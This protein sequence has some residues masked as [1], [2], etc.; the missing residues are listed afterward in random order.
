ML[1]AY[2]EEQHVK[3]NVVRR[4]LPLALLV[5][6]CAAAVVVAVS[7]A[8]SPMGGLQFTQAGHWVANSGLGL[9][10]HVNG[11]AGGVDARAEVPGIEPGS[12]VVQ[13]ETSG[14]V[15]GRSRVTEFGKSTLSVQRSLT[16][17]TGEEPIAVETAGGPYLVYREAGSV[18]RLGDP[19]A[20][21][22][23]G[24]RLGDP[25]GTPDGT[26][27][28]HRVDSG[29]L[30]RLAKDAG[31]ISCPITL[32]AGHTGALTTVGGRAVFV[33][34][35][36]DVLR[37]ISGD[38][39]GEPVPIGTDV[40]ANARVAPADA[41]GRIAILDQGGRRV[42]FVATDGLAGRGSTTPLGTV[43]LPDGDY[44]GPTASGSSVVLLD[45]T[46]NTVL[47]YD[48]HGKPQERTTIPHENGQP[49]LTRA[50]DKRV[51]VDGAEGRHV[52][53]VDHDGKVTQVPVVGTEGVDKSTT[54]QA[55][56]AVPPP[57]GSPPGT[58]TAPPNTQ[59]G[60]PPQRTTTP[61]PRRTTQ[62]PAPSSRTAQ[63][64][65][66]VPASPPGIPPGV[67]AAVQ[68]GNIRVTWGTAAN[69]G[70]PVTAYQVSW[71]PGGGGASQPAGVRSMLITGLRQGVVYT[72]TVVAQN[73]AGRGAPGT[74]QAMIPVAQTRTVTVSRGKTERHDDNCDVP[75]CGYM[76]I[77]MRG[78]EPRKRYH[79]QPYSNG[80]YDNPGV[81]LSTDANGDL[82]FERFLFGQV[83]KQVWVVV[84]GK[85]SNHFTWVSG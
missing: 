77:E 8:A 19:A 75:E 82:T 13:G 24:G 43:V 54:S 67:T 79:I 29:S 17:P 3:G 42:L 76:H 47:T 28:L 64:P 48:N 35:S 7:G 2:W 57:A 71:N 1:G 49:R 6:V 44:A 55:P 59:T 34:T 52:L 16:P 36:A 70:A 10:F 30:C 9:V 39:L 66:A 63:P 74:A 20:R 60:K 81:A 4:R 25:V 32:P 73:S 83:G 5:A 22:A 51:Y 14:Y 37:D 50:E 53:V 56:P 85:E 65:P 26:L 62:A 72:I 68:S 45:L 38:R 31:S 27:W 78:F 61:P 15:V 21:I 23:G 46:R 11:G 84:D 58:S 40:P 41:D 18:V 33:D 80:S 69:N 12:Q